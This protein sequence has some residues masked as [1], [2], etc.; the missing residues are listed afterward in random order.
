[1]N[2]IKIN[3]VEKSILGLAKGQKLCDL[4]EVSDKDRLFLDI[5]DEVDIPINQN[6]YIILA[7]GEIFTVGQSDI[8][9]NPTLRQKIS[10]QLNGEEIVLS[11]AKITGHDIRK[12]DI[13]MESSKLYGDISNQP[14]Q[15]IKDDFRL[16][17][18]HKDCFITIPSSED[19]IIDVEECTKHDRKPPK[20]QNKYRIKIDGDK[21][22]TTTSHLLGKGILDLAGKTW[23]EF[24]LQ[25]KFKGGKREVIDPNHDVDFSAKGVERFETI[26]KHPQQGRY[27]F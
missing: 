24:G 12:E 21:Y 11:V 9:D 15:L 26:P 18:K 2:M 7:G 4:A 10:I 3:G 16:I 25:Q 14:D 6:D 5:K 27:G 17:V 23:Q 8:E 1:M 13:T 22:I 19:G 20:G